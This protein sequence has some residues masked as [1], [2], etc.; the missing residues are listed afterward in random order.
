[1]C[2]EFP[3]DLAQRHQDVFLSGSLRLLIVEDVSGSAV[4]ATQAQYIVVPEWRNCSFQ[5][6]SAS[7]TFADLSRESGRK[8]HL[9]RLAHEAERLLDAL[10]RNQAEERRLLQLYGQ[11]VAKRPVKYRIASAIDKVG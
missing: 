9:C 1:M 7:G 8:P 6:G 3:G 4:P 10:L 5:Y 2:P 11:S